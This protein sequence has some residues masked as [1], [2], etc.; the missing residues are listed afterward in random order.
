MPLEKFDFSDITDEHKYNKPI[1]N[2]GSNII[3]FEERKKFKSLEAEKRDNLV[4]ADTKISDESIS[5]EAKIHSIFQKKKDTAYINSILID[6][7][8]E[9]LSDED[10]D[11]EIPE[12][13][14]EEFEEKKAILEKILKDIS[15]EEDDEDEEE[16]DENNIII[17]ENKRDFYIPM[18]PKKEY[19]VTVE[20]LSVE[21]A[22]PNF[23]ISE[24]D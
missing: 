9:A 22:K 12:E 21:K 16:E 3:S 6:M 14:R 23:I 24:N 17:R 18:K 20:I 19:E 2:R 8:D 4:Y 13:M 7:D 10:I 5:E 15:A 11:D 1:Y